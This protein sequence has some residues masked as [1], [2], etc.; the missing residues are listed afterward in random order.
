MLH[1][2]EQQQHRL[3]N[4]HS[5]LQQVKIPQYTQSKHNTK[6]FTHILNVHSWLVECSLRSASFSW[7]SGSYAV[8][9][10]HEKGA[11]YAVL[12]TQVSQMIGCSLR[13]ACLSWRRYTF[14]NQQTQQQ[15]HERKYIA[16]KHV[17]TTRSTVTRKRWELSFVIASQNVCRVIQWSIWSKGSTWPKYERRKT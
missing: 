4:Q 16:R 12:L 11:P 15:S 3:C 17:P 1:T 9:V 6:N 5:P 14:T 10:D 8:H 7:K 13:R 2:K